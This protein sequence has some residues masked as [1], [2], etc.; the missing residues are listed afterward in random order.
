MTA[1]AVWSLLDALEH[2]GGATGVGAS[3]FRALVPSPPPD[4][5]MLSRGVATNS[6]D[7]VKGPHHVVEVYCTPVVCSA[8]FELEC[9]R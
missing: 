8:S 9:G 4:P 1:P 7:I 5:L 6:P 2:G 3:E